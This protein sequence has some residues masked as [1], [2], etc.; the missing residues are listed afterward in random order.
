[1]TEK[2]VET[3]MKEN[4]SGDNLKNALEFAKYLKT[5][6]MTVN[7]AEVS[8]NGKPVCYMHLD[9]GT[10]YPSPWTIWT[11]SGGYEKEHQDIPLCEDMKKI[12]WTNVNICGKCG[13][14]CQ[15]GSTKVIFGKEFENVCSSDMAFHVPSSEALEVIKKLIEMKK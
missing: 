5:N 15:P 7:G 10:D 3:V 6:E 12:A 14:G 11:S 8:Y 1:M 9:S 2:C 4:L 13:G